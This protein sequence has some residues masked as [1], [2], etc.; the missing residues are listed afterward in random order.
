METMAVCTHHHLRCHTC[1]TKT[2][3]GRL[4]GADLGHYSFN[5]SSKL[6]SWLQYRIIVGW[7]LKISVV[8]S[9]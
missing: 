7:F 4:R 2:A 8:M 5:V 6:T 3:V 1:G 9:I